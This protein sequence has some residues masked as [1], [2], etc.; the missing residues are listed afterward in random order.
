ME[1]RPIIT[2]QIIKMVTDQ[3]GLTAKQIAERVQ[4]NEKTIKVVLHRLVKSNRLMRDKV[5]HE[6]K[7]KSGPQSIYAYKAV[8][9]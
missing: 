3:P 5:A 8:S 7:A 9:Q 6:V 2:Q 4:K 1:P